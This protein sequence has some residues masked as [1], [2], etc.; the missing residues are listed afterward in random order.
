MKIIT[1]IVSIMLFAVEMCYSQNNTDTVSQSQKKNAQ[2]NAIAGNKQNQ[3]KDNSSQSTLYDVKVTV[4]ALKNRTLECHVRDHKI[5]VD[6]PKQ[7]GADDLG[8][9]PPEMLA[10]SYGSCVVSTM[11]FLANQRN[12]ALSNITVTIDGQIDFAKAM[13]VSNKKRAGFQEL[14][15]K[16]SFTSNMTSSE[17]KKFINQVLEVGAAIDNI[18]NPTPVKL[19]IIE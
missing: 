7:F 11:Q 13:G 1:I 15:V 12:I 4:R 18:A 14:G 5:I 17:K 8:P 9:T 16:I 19:E 6:Q 2:A 3:N 10:I